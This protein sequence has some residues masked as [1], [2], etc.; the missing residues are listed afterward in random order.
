MYFENTSMYFDPFTKVK[1]SIEIDDEINTM[2]FE[3]ERLPTNMNRKSSHPIVKPNTS[4]IFLRGFSCF[5]KEQLE[6]S[7]KFN[8]FDLGKS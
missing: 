1:S 6:H 5:V 3:C 8:F 4:R 2:T 7:L